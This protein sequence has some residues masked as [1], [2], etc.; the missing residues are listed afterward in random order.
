MGVYAGLDVSLDAVSICVVGETGE[1]L[2]QGKVLGEPEAVKAALDRWR[3][4]LA[5]VGLEAGAT[6]EWIG[7][8]LVDEGFP[9]VCLE[10]RHVKAA[11][12]AMTVK[13]DRND[14]HGIAQIVRTGWFKTVHLKSAAGQ[15]LR[16]LTAARK[17]AVRALTG[18]EQVIRG[19]LRPLS[20]KIGAVTRVRF[21]ARVRHL[22]GTDRLLLSV[23]EPLLRLHKSLRENLAD[24]HRLVLRAVRADPVCRRLMTM[25]GIGPVTALTYRA[26]IDDPERFRRSRS[27]GAYL[28]LTPRRYQSGEVD[29]VGR[30]TKVGDGDTRTALFE[31][32]NAILR[33]TTRWSS[34]KAWAMKIADRQGVRRA[35]VALAR[36]MAVTLHRMWVDEQD[37]RW[38][39]A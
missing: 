39:A 2:W 13:T 35:K 4:G 6:S 3:D 38:T 29:R 32:A 1:M 33:P 30:I 19:L 36:R 22:V 34:M 31:A 14:A 15:R 17:A 12:S 16:T 10:S 23:F 7:G 9:V 24:L 5:R 11:L 20:L 27:V 18:N 8:H 25:P 21:E 28:G 26:T 37:F